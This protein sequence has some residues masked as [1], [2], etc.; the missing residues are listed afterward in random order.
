ML[1][2]KT[3]E[4]PTEEQPPMGSRN[5]ERRNQLLLLAVLVTVVGLFG[6]LV[7]YFIHQIEEDKATGWFKGTQ[8]NAVLT[9]T[10][11]IQAIIAFFGVL[12]LE[13]PHTTKVSPVTKGGM[14]TVIA[15]LAAITD[16]LMVATDQRFFNSVLLHGHSYS[17]V[18]RIGGD[19]TKSG[20]WKIDVAKSGA[21][22][23]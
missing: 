10:L 5:K 17:A 7:W 6:A 14:R 22:H 11:F 12:N 20:P 1:P 13:E 19:R 9:I 18:S 4:K 15:N 16:G 2:H 3:S 23:A 21:N 8:H